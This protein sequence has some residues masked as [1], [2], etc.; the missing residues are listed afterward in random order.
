MNH[1]YKQNKNIKFIFVTPIYK[2]QERDKNGADAKND[3]GLTQQDY[4]DAIS[5]HAE[6]M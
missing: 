6:K 1:I 4:R 3:L 2:K 5:A